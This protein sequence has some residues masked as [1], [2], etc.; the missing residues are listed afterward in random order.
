MKRARLNI[1]VDDPAIRKQ[2]KTAAA[3]RDLL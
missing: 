3:K 1:Y 2:V